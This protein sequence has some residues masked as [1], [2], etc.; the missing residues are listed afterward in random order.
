MFPAKWEI[1]LPISQRTAHP[2]RLATPAVLFRIPTK[3]LRLESVHPSSPK[4]QFEGGQSSTALRKCKGAVAW[5]LTLSAQAAMGARWQFVESGRILQ[6]ALRAVGVRKISPIV[7]TLSSRFRKQGVGR[8]AYAKTHIS[9][10]ATP[11]A[12][13]ERKDTRGTSRKHVLAGFMMVSRLLDHYYPTSLIRQNR[14]EDS[15]FGKA[16]LYPLER[17]F[18]SVQIQIS[19]TRWRFPAEFSFRVSYWQSYRSSRD[20]PLS[21]QEDWA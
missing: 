2:S 5:F 10:P 9:W 20:L 18:T 3:T 1:L 21:C 14:N 17:L 15:L 6:I 7:A 12:R 4:R 8:R 16:P 13:V 11:H 19:F